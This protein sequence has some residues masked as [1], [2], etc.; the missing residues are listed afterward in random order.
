MM[1]LLQLT[2]RVLQSTPQTVWSIEATIYQRS[3]RARNTLDPVIDDKEDD[4]LLHDPN[5][6]RILWRQAARMPRRVRY[7]KRQ[8]P[9]GTSSRQCRL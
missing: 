7:R 1:D 5:K 8:S 3:S 9:Q 6:A 2:A 4:F